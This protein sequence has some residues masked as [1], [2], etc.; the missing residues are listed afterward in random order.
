MYKVGI[1]P[2]WSNLGLVVLDENNKKVFST[3]MTPSKYKTTYQ[4]V[5]AVEDAL[6]PYWGSVDSAAIEKYVVYGRGVPSK[7]AI[8]TTMMVGA[9]QY[10]FY[11][12][13]VNPQLYRAIDWKQKVCKELYKTKDFRN[14]S[15]SFDKKFS[16][17]AAE[18]ICEDSFETDH[19]ADAACLAFQSHIGK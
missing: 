18:C 6:E 1:D 19:E 13:G 4:A 16:F 15:S 12:K 10:M 5:K 2:G 17:A 11:G 14:P 7:A 9:L 3:N 8:D